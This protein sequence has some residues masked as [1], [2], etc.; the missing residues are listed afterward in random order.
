[1]SQIDLK[2]MTRFD[3]IERVRRG[4][5]LPE[6]RGSLDTS[7]EYHAFQQRELHRKW[8]T[9]AAALA[10]LTAVYENTC[11]QCG[12]PKDGPGMAFKDGTICIGPNGT[13]H[14]RPQEG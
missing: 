6:E 7:R 4:W 11:G 14:S 1:M 13:T 2:T 12:C 5:D 3:A 9:L 10:G 8:P